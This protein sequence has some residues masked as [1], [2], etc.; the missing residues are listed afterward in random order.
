MRHDREHSAPGG[1]RRATASEIR[2]VAPDPCCFSALASSLAVQSLTRIITP[3]LLTLTP[4]CCS[5]CVLQSKKK[6]ADADATLVPELEKLDSDIAAAVSAAFREFVEAQAK[7]ADATAALYREAL[8]AT[9][10]P[11]PVAEEAK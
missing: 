9:E 7:L 2:R 4:A 11:A 5:L 8:A 10:S 6:F 1:L 3:S